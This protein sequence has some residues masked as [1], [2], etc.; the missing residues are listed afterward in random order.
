MS[1]FENDIKDFFEGAEFQ[2][3]DRVWKGVEADLLAK[4]KKG[5]IIYWPYYSAAAAVVLALGFLFLFPKEHKTADPVNTTLPEQLRQSPAQSIISDNDS[6]DVINNVEDIVVDP[7]N[8]K[9]S[10]NATQPE[11]GN[12][13]QVLAQN[14]EANEGALGNVNNKHSELN[15]AEEVSLKEMI[16][17]AD[18]GGLNNRFEIPELDGDISPEL[19][20]RREVLKNTVAD[21]FNNENSLFGGM[22]SNVFDAN[23]SSG[24]ALESAANNTFD[25]QQLASR[26]VVANGSDEQLGALSFGMGM[27]FDLTD[28][29]FLSGGLRYSE[30]R[31]SNYSN[32]YSED[33]NL[34]YPIYQPVGF[35]EDRIVF[36]ADY[37]LTNTIK[38]GGL[39]ALVGYRVL[40]FGKFDVSAKIGVGLDYFFSYEI[41]G[42]LPGLSVRKVDL[43]ET[44]FVNRVNTSGIT[45]I[46]ISYRIN[47]QFGI[48]AG[49]TYQKFVQPVSEN[50][51]EVTSRPSVL[52]FGLMLNYYLGK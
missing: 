8:G 51:F 26:S 1:N 13:Q 39:Q 6:S 48:N 16:A 20:V 14:G 28:R 50:E 42:D 18:K 36:V 31:F 21:N 22:G 46:D 19:F 27:S 3:S 41:K 29:W 37:N 43:D 5:L 32:S 52:G 25:A 44:N 40:S 35:D 9:G 38:S 12:Y 45:G 4:K 49:A 11:G 23:P 34:K 24:A 2:P 7:S 30:Y 15:L 10:G 17:F 47:E 33:G